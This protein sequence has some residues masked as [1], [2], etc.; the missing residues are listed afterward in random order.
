MRYRSTRGHAPALSFPDTVLTGLAAD[1][2]LY[3]PESLPHF[4]PAELESFASLPYAALAQRI[5]LPFVEGTL[6]AEELS[7]LLTETYASFRHAAVAPLVQIGANDWILELFHGPTLAFK[8]FALQFLGRLLSGLLAKRGERAV[9]LGATSG[10]TGS[11]AIAGFR[12]LPKTES[13]ILFPAGRVSE[14]QRRQMTSVPDANVHCVAVE[15][16]FDDCQHLVKTLFLDE[17]FRTRHHLVAVNSINWARVLA[18]TVYYFYAALRLGAPHRS[19]AFS[20][21]TGN[22]G[23]IYAGYLA[24]RMG[25]PVAD[26][27]IASN[28][29]DILT[30]CHA[31][32]RYAVGEVLP[33]LSPSMDIQVSSNF[34]RLLFDL[35]AQEGTA[36]SALMDSL[37]HSGAFTLGAHEHAA[38]RARFS[39]ARVEDTA[40]RACIR[41][42]YQRCGYLLDPHTAVGVAAS[43]EARR[44]PDAPMVTLATAHPAKFP[45]SVLEASGVHPALPSHLADIF[46]RPERCGFLPADAEA[47][48]KFI[49]AITR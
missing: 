7:A 26:L 15:G 31:T 29:N 9:V 27:L 48:K 45:E 5:L 24:A 43:R 35:Y 1:G 37:R 22:F 4:S 11:A 41:E 30:R 28:H 34:E 8:D 16:T 21:P 3:V 47:L 36:V 39:A 14:V 19:V 13:V 20:V 6:S 25:L 42:T 2:G 10:D 46:S 12:G 40:I 23:D 38:F 49:A 33:S 32:G 18:Q 44:H 17:A